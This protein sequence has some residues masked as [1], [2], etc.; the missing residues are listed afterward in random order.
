M[1]PFFL[2]WMQ[3][4]AFNLLTYPNC[5]SLIQS[6]LQI[7]EQ[8]WQQL[9]NKRKIFNL[10]TKASIAWHD[11]TPPGSSS[12]HGGHI[13]TFFPLLV[14]PFVGERFAHFVRLLSVLG[15]WRSRSWLL[16]KIQQDKNAKSQRKLI[17]GYKFMRTISTATDQTQQ[18]CGLTS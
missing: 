7:Q 17:H 10:I 9:K 6:A 4:W 13:K 8:K 18:A 15:A 3:N 11:N 12:S 1:I 5:Y 14:Y 2:Q 16:M